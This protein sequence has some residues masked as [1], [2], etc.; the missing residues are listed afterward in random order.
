MS[1]QNKEGPSLGIN[2]QYIKDISFENPDPVKFL[3]QENI[4][5]FET[6]LDINVAPEKLNDTLFSVALRIGAKVLHQK[7]T[8][9][10]IDL[11]Y[12]GIFDIRNAPEDF[13]KFLLFVEC[14]RLL[15]PFSREIIARVTQDSGFPPLILRP[16][17]FASLAQEQS[18]SQETKGPSIV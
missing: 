1:E 15:F 7:E 11:D 3:S 2:L 6:E 17:D 14:P 18:A 10:L 8:V 12:I 4:S 16:I 13:L 5:G 9:Y